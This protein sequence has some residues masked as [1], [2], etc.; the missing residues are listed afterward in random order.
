MNFHAKKAVTLTDEQA[1]ELIA[2]D[3]GE[4]LY[5]FGMTAQMSPEARDKVRAA[6]MKYR[7]VRAK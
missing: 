3:N 2:E 7:P 1:D 5:W 4:H 6:A